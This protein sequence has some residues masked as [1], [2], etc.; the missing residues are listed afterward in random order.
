LTAGAGNRQLANVEWN[1]EDAKV[2]FIFESLLLGAVIILFLSAC[3][4]SSDA[5]VQEDGE[6]QGSTTP[7]H[8][9]E[10]VEYMEGRAFDI[11]VP[12]QEGAWPIVV[13]FHGGGMNG[14]SLYVFSAEIASRGAIVFTP[15]WVHPRPRSTTSQGSGMRLFVR[16]DT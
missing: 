3:T 15:T 11:F 12:D 7:I 16:C 2:I 13:L 1:R 4:P 5:P 14:R 6:R 10:A 8:I 9:V